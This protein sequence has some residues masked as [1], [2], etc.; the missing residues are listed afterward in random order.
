MIGSSFEESLLEQLKDKEFAVEFI[1]DALACIF[2]NPEDQEVWLTSP[3]DVFGGKSPLEV[4]TA[5]E[6]GALE[7]YWYIMYTFKWLLPSWKDG[8]DP[9]ITTT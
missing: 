8:D 5:D 2:S 4:A 7:V 3:N 9:H 6:R 1:R